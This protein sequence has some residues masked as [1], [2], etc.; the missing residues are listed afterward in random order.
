[1]LIALYGR[2]GH[3]SEILKLLNNTGMVYGIDQDPTAIEHNKNAFKDLNNFKVLEGNFL[4]ISGL[5]ALENVFKVDGILYDLGVS[6]PQFDIPERGFSYRY[7][8]PLDMRMD[9]T[10]NPLTAA[11]IKK[12]SL[13][14][15][16]RKQR[17]SENDY[18]ISKLPVNVESKKEF[19]LVIKK[20]LKA[21]SEELEQNNRAHSSKLF[22]IEK[23]I[24]KKSVLNV[25]INDQLIN[26][27]RETVYEAESVE[28]EVNILTIKTL[29]KE[30][31]IQVVKD[32]G[33][34]KV[35]FA[36]TEIY[37]L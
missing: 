16:L 12:E 24:L 25:R 18:L 28:Y 37:N 14:K 20:P 21:S 3:T 15:S 8:G 34:K 13:K 35:S 26:M 7:D 31:F 1:M 32:C 4:N 33:I 22:V 29:V 10:N 36:S 5:L 27:D 6:S 23:K 11:V 17:F 19:Q 9:T 30:N 2:G